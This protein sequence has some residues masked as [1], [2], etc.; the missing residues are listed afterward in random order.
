MINDQRIARFKQ[1][2][3]D[4]L[5]SENL[6][7]YHQLMEQYEAEHNVPGLEIAAALARLVQGNAPLL[8]KGNKHKAKD[9]SEKRKSA[10]EK[11][12]ERRRRKQEVVE[13]MDCY[14]IEVG[15]THG[16]KPGNIVGA[17]ANEA[18]LDSQYIGEIEI[19]D[20]F[21]TVFLPEGMPK[22]IFNDLKA[23][24]VSGQRLRIS[25]L[26]ETDKFRKKAKSAKKKPPKRKSGKKK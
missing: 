7:F 9:L 18:G 14:R 2:I 13:G 3:T 19:Q 6:D 16:V 4:T 20:D 26:N 24:R 25:R 12:P 1:R 10:A 11:K 8:L 22:E 23:V 5:A 15:R 21:S 17:I